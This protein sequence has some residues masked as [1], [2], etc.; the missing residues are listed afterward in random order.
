MGRPEDLQK[1][2]YEMATAYRLRLDDI[3]RITNE[4]QALIRKNTYDLNESAKYWSQKLADDWASTRAEI[5]SLLA[6][7]ADDWASTRAEIESLLARMADDWA[8]TRAEIESLLAG[9]QTVNQQT[10]DAWDE[11]VKAYLAVNR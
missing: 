8:S 11:A 3:S 7:I 4:V 9:M 2:G 5:E 6:R 10:I 1:L